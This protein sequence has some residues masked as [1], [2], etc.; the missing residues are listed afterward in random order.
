MK[1]ITGGY[2]SRFLY[3]LLILI[4][5]FINGGELLK[6]DEYDYQI[7]KLTNQF[8]ECYPNPPYSEILEKGSRA[9]KC[10]LLQ[11]HY[12]YFICIPFRSEIHH[13]YAYLF[14]DS[15]RSQKHR[16]GLDYTKMIIVKNP[17][18]IDNIDTF[19]DNDEYAELRRNINRIKDEAVRFLEE[20]IEH[21]S[22]RKLLHMSEFKRRYA[23]STIRYFH[24]E[25][26]LN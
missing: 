1:I 5:C 24:K 2:A 11:M 8:Y 20:Y 12:D 3:R 17:L 21:V 7:L 18:F 16:S 6:P 23:Y 13:K 14:K 25:L 10:L 9:Y 22:G 4:V 26:G 19:I 15:Q